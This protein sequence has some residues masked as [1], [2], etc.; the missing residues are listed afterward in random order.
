[1]ATVWAP[2][3]ALAKIKA[4]ALKG[5][6]AGTELVFE[7][8]TAKIAEPPKTGRIYRRRGVEHQASAPGEAPATDVGTLIQSGSTGYDAEEV[9]GRANWSAKHAPF[10]EFGTA[11]MDPRP[12]ARPSLD[13]KASE[14][15]ELIAAGVAAEL[16]G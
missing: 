8:A 16:R 12:F 7:T 1:M 3:I 9:V 10:L 13:E 11:R 5:V 4:G 14:V 6:V 2:E 15:Q